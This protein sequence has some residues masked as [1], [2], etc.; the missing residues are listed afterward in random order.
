MGPGKRVATSIGFNTAILVISVG[1]RDMELIPS[2]WVW[3][4]AGFL[5]LCVT[6]WSIRKEMNEAFSASKLGKRIALFKRQQE[7]L[8]GKQ[9]YRRKDPFGLW[10]TIKLLL[11]IGVGIPTFLIIGMSLVTGTFFFFM[12]VL[13]FFVPGTFEDFSSGFWGSFSAPPSDE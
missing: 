2:G 7:P 4:S 12:W 9:T 3:L 11:Q 5:I 1:V 10:G 8:E 6:V 13:D